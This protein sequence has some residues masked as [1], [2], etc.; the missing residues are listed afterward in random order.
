MC[1]EPIASG[2]L[3]QCRLA[4]P[5]PILE[6]KELELWLESKWCVL[7]DADGTF[8]VGF[9]FRDLT[10]KDR[11]ILKFL[12]VPWEEALAAEKAAVCDP[13]GRMNR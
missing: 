2:K 5:E 11:M 13:M 9:E 7:N 10:E 12:I 8:E 3:Y 4:L 6:F 1:R